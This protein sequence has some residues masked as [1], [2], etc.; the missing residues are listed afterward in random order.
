VALVAE[1]KL[2]RGTNNSAC[3]AFRLRGGS[4][5]AQLRRRAR[6]HAVESTGKRLMTQHV[7]PVSLLRTIAPIRKQPSG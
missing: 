5:V 6:Q 2:Y 7:G 3:V 1:R 4:H